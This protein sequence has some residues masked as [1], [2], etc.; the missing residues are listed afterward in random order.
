MRIAHRYSGALLCDGVG[1]GKT[2]IGL[3]V[4]ERLLFERKRVALIV[5][6][7]ARADVWEAKLRRFLPEVRG[8]FS[9]LVI[10]NHTDLMRG[11]EYTELIQEVAEKVDAI[12]VDEAHH[13]RNIASDRSRK[14]FEIT[15]GKQLFLLTATPVN[16]SLYDLMHLIEYFSRRVPEYFS[17]APLGI[18]TLRGHFRKMEDA[19]QSIVDGN[20]G[21]VE[22]DP[23]A[24]EHILSGDELFQTL[25]VQ[26]S[27]AYVR[28][29][30][31]NQGGRDVAF[32]Q[33]RTLRSPFTR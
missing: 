9:N 28:Q 1:L 15:E 7:A 21:D 6:K 2:F 31:I 33:R 13:F 27:R 20:K 12:I 4:I 22:I 19:L 23:V 26:R 24:A 14:F 17:D 5:P 30:L 8:H 25:V 18:H 16:N 29:S 11:G 10:Y 3:M 32:P